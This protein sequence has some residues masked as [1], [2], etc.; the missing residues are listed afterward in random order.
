MQTV[1]SESEEQAKHMLDYLLKQPGSVTRDTVGGL[2]TIAIN[3]IGSAGYGHKRPWTPQPV[4]FSAKKKLSYSDSIYLVMLNLLPAVFFSP[5]VLKLPF[6]PESWRLLGKAMEDLPGDTKAMLEEE[7][8]LAKSRDEHV[9]NFMTM[10]VSLSTQEKD[11]EGPNSS[12]LSEEEIQGNLFSF[13]G[14]GFDTTSNA[15]SYAVTMLAAYPQWQSWL[16]EEL[17]NLIPDPSAPVHYEI[18]YPQLHR[19][20]AVMVGLSDP[21]TKPI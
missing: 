11:G 4:S 20:L 14:A 9:P 16:Q 21:W 15:M 12:Y 3:V 7:R 8:Q 10:L 13:T 5:A 17:D 19:C 1:W 18:V 6:M 2:R